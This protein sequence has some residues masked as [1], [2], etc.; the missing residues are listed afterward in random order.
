MK[1]S[2]LLNLKINLNIKDNKLNFNEIKI[3]FFIYF[4]LNINKFY[5]ENNK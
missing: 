3:F 4:I 5:K 1:I 2:I